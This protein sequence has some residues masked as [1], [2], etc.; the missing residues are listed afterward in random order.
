MKLILQDLE[1]LLGNDLI[2]HRK[3]P[4]YQGSWMYI[5]EN[6]ILDVAKFMKSKS[7][8]L[9]ALV[10]KENNDSAKSVKLVYIFSTSK[11]N[12]NPIFFIETKLK[13][14]IAHIS[15]ANIFS[16][17]K[18]WEQELTNRHR[19]LFPSEMMN[20]PSVN[21]NSTL[22]LNEHTD[23]LF[24]IPY[25]IDSPSSNL[26]RREKSI[27]NTGIF[28]PIH[29]DHSYLN[30]AVN[31]N[32]KIQKIEFQDGWQFK[33][34]EQQLN[35]HEIFEENPKI[36]LKICGKNPIAYQIA[37]Y[38][39]LEDFF[40]IKTS[41]KTRFMRTYLLEV[42]RLQS[43]LIW[44]I[45]LARIMD[46]TSTLKRL[47]KLFNDFWKKLGQID[48][49]TSISNA[50]KFG[51]VKNLNPDHA[52]RL[53][54][55]LK[56]N[57]VKIFNSIKKFAL[58]P[59]LKTALKG[60]GTISSEGALNFGLTGPSLRGSGI[61]VDTRA[62][63]VNLVYTTN[64]IAKNWSLITFP[65][66]DCYARMKVRLWEI[67]DSLN[68]CKHIL[69]DIMTYEKTIFSYNLPENPILPKDEHFISSI[70]T[71]QGNLTLIGNT[72]PIEE[73]EK[74]QSLKI[75]TPDIK[76]FS[77]LNHYLLKNTP[78]EDLPIIMHSLDLHFSR[79]D[80]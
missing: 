17:V 26:N 40:N 8:H 28:N 54:Y 32:Q 38:Q 67:H 60:V 51:T 57:N 66:G 65:E 45:N 78:I 36:L 46:D 37:Y 34:I 25:S 23:E 18:F 5:Q 20:S 69:H 3:I 73:N 1:N 44:F 31:T 74:W 50:V 75:I 63:D 58:T 48:P 80:L 30:I 4:K 64:E 39:I 76:N 42:E 79:I 15:I 11:I 14:K 13:N 22:S 27:F 56:K 9:D 68:I 55:Y 61:P 41:F 62:S 24:C 35:S 6:R 10:N 47:K 70:E 49:E 72:D 7:Y 12:S 43:H 71:P 53:Y 33:N 59:Y 16:N 52:H 29:K 77:I 2:K 21:L 19:I